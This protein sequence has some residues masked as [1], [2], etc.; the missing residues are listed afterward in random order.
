[1]TA[2]LIAELLE[3]R[4]LLS[5]FESRS[6]NNF[7]NLALVDLGCQADARRC[8]RNNFANLALERVQEI[9]AAIA[10]DV[11][12]QAAPV[13]NNSL[14]QPRCF[15]AGEKTNAAPA[16]GALTDEQIDLIATQQH[17]TRLPQSRPELIQF[18]RAVLAANVQPK[19]TGL[20]DELE[21]A[22][23]ALGQ[24]R[25]PAYGDALALCRRLEAENER[26][27]RSNA[28]LLG[29]KQK[30][31]RRERET[32][33]QA[34]AATQAPAPAH[35]AV[36]A[37]ERLQRF[38]FE[39]RRDG[40]EPLPAGVVK[41]IDDALAAVPVPS[42]AV[43]AG[44]G[45]QDTGGHIRAAANAK[46]AQQADDDTRRLDYLQ[47]RQATISLVPDGRDEH[48]TRHAFMFGGWHCSVNRDVRACI[49]A[50]MAES[51]PPVQPTGGA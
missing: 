34:Q 27:H 23:V 21:R 36:A 45:R 22:R 44:D 42:P 13:D 3:C 29:A 1:M 14:G 46:V 40:I 26:L 33:E 35:P 39:C 43:G 28:A 51:K 47:K 48:G 49:D 50:A 15:P 16:E 37:L 18:A 8:S 20:A 24:E 41:V 31:E 19:G 38:D 10:K 25:T 7:A 30:A 11:A 4:D 17:R 9:D 6:R 12:A 32:I 5:S 2:D